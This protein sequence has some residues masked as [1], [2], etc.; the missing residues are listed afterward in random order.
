MAIRTQ[1]H[2]MRLIDDIVWRLAQLASLPFQ[3]RYVIGGTSVEY[4]L[5]VELLENVDGLKYVIEKSEHR[6]TLN[7]KQ[8]AELEELF[9]LIENSSGEALSAVDRAEA[10]TRIRESEV[11][12]TLREKATSAL[13]SFGISVDALTAEEVDK[14]S[15]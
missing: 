15:E 8:L 5:D 9:V 7:R 2:D 6:A 13:R 10:A 14:L 4:V 11:W 1:G 12:K 3:E